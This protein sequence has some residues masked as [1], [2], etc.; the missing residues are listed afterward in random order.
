VRHFVMSS[1]VTKVF[2]FGGDLALFV[3]LVR[4]DKT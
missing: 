3:R 4:A 2:S 1:D